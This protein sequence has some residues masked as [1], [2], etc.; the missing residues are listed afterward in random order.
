MQWLTLTS[1]R[2]SQD[3]MFGDD[4]FWAAKNRQWFESGRAV[5]GQFDTQLGNRRRSS[6]N[7]SRIRTRTHIGMPTIPPPEQ[8]AKL[9]I[10]ILTI[11]GSY[12]DDQP[13]ALAHY[14]EHM[15]HGSP[16]GSARHYLVIGP[17]D[18]AG[19]RTPTAEFGGLTFGPASL[20]D[21]PKLHLDWYAW[22]MRSGPKP[23][24]LQKPGR[25]LRDGCREVA[26]RR[27]ARSGDRQARAYY[28]DPAADAGDCFASGSL[29]AAAVERRTGSIRLRSARV[30]GAKL[31]STL[32]GLP[33]RSALIYAQQRASNSSITPQPFERDT[34]ISGFFRL[35][36]W[37]AIDQPDT[38]FAG[39]RYEIRHRRQSIR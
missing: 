3:R 36:A 26:L 39:E 28:L 5:Q 1:G 13:G 38:D 7:G 27:H 14:R 19:T 20:V 35:S 9:S 18:H 33:H 21:L 11:T 4:K 24:F 30:S 2:A 10:P 6:R 29:G 32:D 17:W 8:Y 12:D 31:E 16:E 34:E 25:L 22:T 23:E 15:K 37:I